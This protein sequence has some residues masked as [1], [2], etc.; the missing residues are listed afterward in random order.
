MGVTDFVFELLTIKAK[1][2]DTV[3]MLVWQPVTK[4]DHHNFFNHN[5]AFT[6]YHYFDMNQS[7]NKWAITSEGGS[8]GC[9]K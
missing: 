1:I 2:K 7:V 3:Y 9:H 8:K 6:S 5:C 4:D